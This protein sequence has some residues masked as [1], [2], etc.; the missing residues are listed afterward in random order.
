MVDGCDVLLLNMHMCNAWSN[1]RSTGTEGRS[2]GRRLVRVGLSAG[3]RFCL[4][5]LG[6]CSCSCPRF[7]SHSPPSTQLLTLVSICV[8][9]G[10]G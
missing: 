6:V 9:A 5:S 1:I 7:R 2:V 4:C 3:V 8:R 10:P